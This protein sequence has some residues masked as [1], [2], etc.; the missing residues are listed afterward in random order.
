M[1][2]L[3][4]LP[5]VLIMIITT[6]TTTTIGVII[7][8]VILNSRFPVVPIIF[9]K[10]LPSKFFEHLQTFLCMPYNH[11]F[12][13]VWS[14]SVM[15]AIYDLPSFLYSVST[16]T[17]NF[18]SYRQCCFSI[19][20]FS[21]SLCIQFQMFTLKVLL[22]DYYHSE[23]KCYFVSPNIFNIMDTVS[24]FCSLSWNISVLELTGQSKCG[25]VLLILQFSHQIQC[26]LLFLKIILQI[27]TNKMIIGCNL[28]IYNSQSV[29]L[30]VMASTSKWITIAG[31]AKLKSCL[32][33]ES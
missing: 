20:F 19:H 30:S 1:F 29:C 12:P 6:T 26:M 15:L 32:V 25:T 8:S 28:S 22:N 2:T 3:S 9:F 14:K 23:A 13:V 18:L 11:V 21:L 4:H 5:F 10:F 24:K 27:G 7:D 31:S 17:F 33:R 16:T